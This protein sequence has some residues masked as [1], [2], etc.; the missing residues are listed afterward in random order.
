[1]YNLEDYCGGIILIV[2][3]TLNQVKSTCRFMP[4]KCLTLFCIGV[5]EKWFI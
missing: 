4:K 3:I 5:I 2:S 1:M